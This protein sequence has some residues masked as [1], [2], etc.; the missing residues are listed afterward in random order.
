MTKRYT[1]EDRQA[2]ID[3]FIAEH[4]SFDPAVF[5]EEARSEN[6]PAHGWFEWDD[7]AAAERYRVWQARQFVH[8][9]VVTRIVDGGTAEVEVEVS[10]PEYVAQQSHGVDGYIPVSSPDGEAELRWQALDSGFGLRSWLKRYESAMLEDEV[11]AAESL[12][13]RIER[14]N[15]KA[16]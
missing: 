11:K 15:A 7:G 16:A 6:H 5:V 1:A 14:N 4:G 13:R 3:L 10:R 2:I 9:R 12:I 8:V